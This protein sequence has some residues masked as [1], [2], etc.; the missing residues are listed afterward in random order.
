VKHQRMNC[1]L[2]ELEHRECGQDLDSVAFVACVERDPEPQPVN[3]EAVS[4]DD[5]PFKQLVDM[6]PLW[7]YEGEEFV[8]WIRRKLYVDH[9]LGHVFSS[10][11]RL[12]KS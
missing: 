10:S 7:W 12:F 1:W 9:K 8:T 4:H 2:E 3:R 11:L 6:R 5:P